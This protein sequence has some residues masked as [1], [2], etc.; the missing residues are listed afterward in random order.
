MRH[1]PRL[2]VLLLAL[3]F[4][5]CHGSLSIDI[6]DDDDSA[7]DDDDAVGDDD[8]SVGDDDDSVG[9]DDDSVG[10]DDDSVGD[11]DDSVGDDDDSVDQDHVDC[12]P[13]VV[14]SA[15]AG[16]VRIFSGDVLLQETSGGWVWDGCEVERYF[17]ASGAL[18]CENHWVV[19]GSMIDWDG[20]DQAAEYFLEFAIQSGP[21]ACGDEGD[22]AWRYLVDYDF[23]AGT[24]ELYWANANQGG[25]NE[26]ADAPF[27]MNSAQT[28][29]EFEY[30][31][32][33]LEA[34]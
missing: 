23:G 5:A 21:T 32:E 2:L 24:L 27:V 11:D 18:D 19:T 16:E 15:G 8:D 31:T 17:D 10:D 4:P 9:D 3:A 33:F 14:P 26:W 12:G 34:R 30:A 28:Q 6:G 29:V 25:W 7:G 20:G 1:S 22:D 13:W